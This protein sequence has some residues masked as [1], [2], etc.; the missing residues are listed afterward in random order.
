MT[1]EG[2]ETPERERERWEGVKGGI[3]RVME[4]EGMHRWVQNE[5][6]EE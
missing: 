1:G 5:E 2:Q 6:G 3:E 4:D